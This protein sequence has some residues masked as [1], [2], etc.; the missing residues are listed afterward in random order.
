MLSVQ[1][2]REYTAPHIRRIGFGIQRKEI[3]A[4]GSVVAVSFADRVL[5]LRVL[6]PAMRSGTSSSGEMRT[7]SP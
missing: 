6:D 7:K 2:Q 3:E 1:C 5:W 4:E